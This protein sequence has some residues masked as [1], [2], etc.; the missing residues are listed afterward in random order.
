[1]TALDRQVE[2]NHRRSRRSFQEEQ[3]EMMRQRQEDIREEN[4][5]AR[6][7]TNL[8]LSAQEGV[9]VNDF[10]RRKVRWLY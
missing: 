4:K 10:R 7:L 6:N 9:G 1:M 3:A 5:L 8:S 2:D